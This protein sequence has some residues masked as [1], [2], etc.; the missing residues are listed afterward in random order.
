MQNAWK[1]SSREAL[2]EAGLKTADLDI[3]EIYGAYPVL[4]CV[5]I[6]ALGICGPGQAG[7]FI[8]E[9]HTSPG[10]KLPCSTMGDAVGRGHTGSGVSIANYVETARQ[11]MGKAGERQVSDCKYA[12]ATSAGGSGMNAITTIWGRDLP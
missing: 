7:K 3:L 5:I 1:E 12:L 6:E 2:E 11:L 8:M 10:G 9:G 4:Q